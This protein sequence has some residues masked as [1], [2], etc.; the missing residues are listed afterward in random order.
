M[1]IYSE[2]NPKSCDFLYKYCLIKKKFLCVTFVRFRYAADG[3]E[4]LCNEVMVRSWKPIEE[5]WLFAMPLLHFLRGDS[6][7][8]EEPDVEGSCDRPEWFGAQNLKIKEF[9]R[10]ATEM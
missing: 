3:I 7:P 5:G 1:F 6:K 10:S 9:Q 2:V 4:K 8:F